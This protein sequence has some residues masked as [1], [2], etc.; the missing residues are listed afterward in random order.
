MASGSGILGSVGTSLGN[1]S[2]HGNIKGHPLNMAIQAG[3]IKSIFPM[4]NIKFDQKQLVW[5]HSLTPSPL[6]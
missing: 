2:F 4:S 5:S 6:K 3:K 1:H